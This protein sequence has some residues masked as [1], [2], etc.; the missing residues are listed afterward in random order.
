MLTFLMHYKL[1]TPFMEK[2]FTFLCICSLIYQSA[3]AHLYSLI[4]LSL[5]KENTLLV[6]SFVSFII[7]NISYFTI[8]RRPPILTW[9]ESRLFAFLISL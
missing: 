5:T 2:L 8:F 1:I 4:L 9:K 6:H 3:K 7:I